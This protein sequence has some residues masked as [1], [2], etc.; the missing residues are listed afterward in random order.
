[1]KKVVLSAMAAILA[2]TAAVP[3]SAWALAPVFVPVPVIVPVPVPVP[4]PAPVAATQASPAATGSSAAG[5]GLAATFGFIGFVGLLATYD[6]IRR[7][8]SSGDFLGLGG[9]GFTTPITPAMSVIPPPK[10]H[11]PMFWRHRK[12]APVVVRVLG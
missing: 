10:C 2:F 1:M 8:N 5:L 7:T 9:P 11:R 12:P 6:I 4:A 3:N